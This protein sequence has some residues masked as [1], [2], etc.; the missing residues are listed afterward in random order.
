M[1]GPSKNNP[2]K[3][4]AKVK[5]KFVISSDC[6]KCTQKCGKGEAYL[7]RYAIK[8]EGNGVWCQK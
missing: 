4:D 7:K 3:R 1:A 2:D 8:K 6:E 5:G